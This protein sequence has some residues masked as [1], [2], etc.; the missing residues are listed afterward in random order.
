MTLNHRISILLLHALLPLASAW[1]TPP[2]IVLI[3]SDDQ[4]WDSI[5]ALSP[6]ILQTPNL[7]SLANH[8]FVFTG[9]RHHGSRGEA[10]CVSSRSSIHSGQQLWRSA[11]DLD[12]RV[13]LGECLMSAGYYA[14]MTGKW[15]N[16]HPAL[17]RSFNAARNVTSGFLST[18]Y[19]VNFPTQ[20]LT[21]GVLTTG[22]NVPPT[23]ATDL[24]GSTATNF[25][26]T[27]NG[28]APFFLYVAFNAPHDPFQ[29][30]NK[31]RAPYVDAHTNSILPLPA[32]YMPQALFNHGVHHIR[33]EV[34]QSRP[35]NEQQLNLDNATYQGM[36]R[37]LDHYVGLIEESLADR[38]WTTN[39]IILFTSDH[40][41]ARGSHGLLGKQNLYEHCLRVPF[42]IKGPG[43]AAGGH[44]DSVVFLHDIYAT[45]ADYA[46]AHPPVEQVDGLSLRPLIEGLIPTH[47]SVA[48]QA[49]VENMRSLVANG[50]KLIEY[51]D[52]GV[53]IRY[54]QL[55]NLA[56]D[57]DEWVNLATDPAYAQSL[58]D[59][60]DL[61]LAQKEVYGDDGAFWSYVQGDTNTVALPIQIHWENGG[62]AQTTTGMDNLITG[63]TDRVQTNTSSP[64]GSLHHG[65][66]DPI[67]D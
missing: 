33:D 9:A 8:G 46:G 12:G 59:M 57:P 53:G 20:S 52:N 61:M 2:N 42:I 63:E 56:S 15:H 44:N 49:Y 55:F 51:A 64:E 17:V 36:I 25:I 18:G 21:N 23:H 16:K 32:N 62:A 4:R 47:R 65:P 58:Q 50:M 34:L 11:D 35:L 60:R 24:V 1:A 39:T 38:N 13:T 45:L 54:T 41:L 26:Q 29:T 48:Y 3:V 6:S 19:T 31:W 22:A 66:Q 27:Y 7:D 30:P 28:T 43:I 40:G 67:M 10:V 5:N 37:Q 14:F